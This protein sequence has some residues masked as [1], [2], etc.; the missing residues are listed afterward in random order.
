MRTTLTL[1]DDLSKRLRD[2]AHR[3]HRSFKAVCN[4]AVRAGLD[5]KPVGKRKKFT[6]PTY[7]MGEPTIDLTKALAIAAE[8]EDQEILRKMALGI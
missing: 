1:D 2:A 6:F 7:N 8:M 5:K 4:D 3:E